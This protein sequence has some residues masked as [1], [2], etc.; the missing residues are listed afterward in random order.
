MRDPG[1][2]LD[3]LGIALHEKG[4]MIATVLLEAEVMASPPVSVSHIQWLDMHDWAE[5]KTN[6]PVAFEAWFRGKLNELLALLSHPATQRFA[7]EVAE[8]ERR[9]QPFSQATEI[10]ALVEHF[11]GRDWLRAKLENWHRNK[12]IA[13]LLAERRRWHR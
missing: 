3:E 2:C 12:K 10:G 8:L 11:V 13:P 7:G 4:G 5:R 1:V 6:D 9:L